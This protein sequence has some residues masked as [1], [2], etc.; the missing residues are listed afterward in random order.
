MKIN[1]SMNHD[2]FTIVGL[3]ELIWDILPDGKQ[4]GGAPSNF[5]YISSLLGNR[6]VVASRVGNDELGREAS[7]RLMRTGVSTA[8]IQVDSDHPTGIVTVT[9]DQHGEATFIPNENSAW[10]HLEWTSSWSRL[11]ESCDAVCF[12]SLGQRS[13]ESR[14]VIKEFLRSSKSS[15]RVFDVNLR[16]SFFTRDLLSDS[17]ELATIVKLNSEELPAVASMLD[18]GAGSDRSMA[19][20]LLKRFDLDLVA[21]TR[22]AEGSLLVT[23]KKADEHP[24]FRVRVVDT[25]GAGDAFTAGLVHFYLHNA[26]LDLINEMANRLGAWVATEKGATPTPPA[27]NLGEVLGKIETTRGLNA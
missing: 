13:P 24:G 19:L 12:G 3:G 16:H 7:D 21:V 15:V 17:L 8:W 5:A 1:T 4:L 25:I 9:V 11:A 20:A 18:V 27:G 2:G 10:D 22:G 26:P 14:L 6:A 23:Q